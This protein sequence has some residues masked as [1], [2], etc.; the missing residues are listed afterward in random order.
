MS[1]FEIGCYVVKLATFQGD[2]LSKMMKADLSDSLGHQRPESRMWHFQ[3]CLEI[4]QVTTIHE[5]VKQILWR[6]IKNL[7][8]MG[9]YPWGAMRWPHL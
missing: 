6:P 7:H 8:V 3:D 1:R 2:D 9:S 4:Q 5:S